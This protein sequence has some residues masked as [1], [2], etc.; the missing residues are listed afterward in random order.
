M[1][2]TEIQALKI[3]FSLGE[4]RT[5]RYGRKFNDIVYHLLTE[6]ASEDVITETVS[7]IKAMKEQT[8]PLATKN[9]KD[10][11]EEVL[12]FGQVY[13]ESR[14]KGILTGGMAETFSHSISNYWST[15][16]SSS[17]LELARYAEKIRSLTAG[18]SQSTVS[19]QPDQNRPLKARGHV[20]PVLHVVSS[21]QSYSQT[22]SELEMTDA[23]Q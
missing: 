15:K 5:Q 4:I 23:Q 1:K 10:L 17:I 18:S 6:Y 2:K 14:L 8:N 9:S 22:T 20:N 11:W 7:E 12:R 16:K 19:I 21:D 13:D 3:R